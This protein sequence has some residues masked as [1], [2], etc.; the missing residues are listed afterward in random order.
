MNYTI[1]KKLPLAEEIIHSLPLSIE[2]HEKILQDRRDVKRILEG[3]D[4]RLLMIVGPC[5]AWPKEAVLEYAERLAILN[6]KVEHALK[7]IMRVYIQ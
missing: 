6:K 1:V 7:I 5:S 2:G 4:S 3:K